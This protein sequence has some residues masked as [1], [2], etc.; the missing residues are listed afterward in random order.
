MQNG[1]PQVPLV[2]VQELLP[3]LTAQ[4]RPVHEEG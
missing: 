1:L 4:T 3:L 2:L